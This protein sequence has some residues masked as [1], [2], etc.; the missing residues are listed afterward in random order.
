MLG[1]IHFMP[2]AE[3]HPL[4]A[5]KAITQM[6]KS[7]RDNQ[8]DMKE[9][10]T[11]FEFPKL[12]GE[13]AVGMT[14][15]HIIDQSR[16]EPQNLTSQRELMIHIWYPS[17]E[18]NKDNRVLYRADE[19]EDAKT[20]L[21]KL[22]YP[23][24]DLKQLDEVFSHAKPNAEFLQK[25]YPYP[26]ILFSHGYLGCMPVDYTSFCEEL[27][28][29]GYIVISIAHTYYAQE[30]TFTDGRKIKPST[31]TLAQ[32]SAPNEEVQNLWAKDVQAVLDYLTNV[33]KDVKDQFHN[34]FD[35]N[36]VGMV[37][38]SMGGA[39]AFR[40]CLNDDRFKAGVS[41]DASPWSQ[42]G[43]HEELKKPFLFIFAENTVQDLQKTDEE[44]AAIHNVPVEAVAKFRAI[45]Q[46]EIRADVVIPEINHGGF[47]DFLLLKDLPLYKNNKHIFNI[48]VMT[49][50]ADGKETIQYI[51]DK[52]IQFFKRSL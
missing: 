40:L 36:R 7:E 17:S 16:K 3:H 20:G 4:I 10:D 31:E 19:I 11:M 23:E 22:G 39:T 35:L 1:M 52:L 18:S 26:V 14:T 30:V 9:S 21:N 15:R 43:S 2:S 24:K 13:Y 48:E 41:F 29:H 6:K 49:G 46:Q 5:E 42:D 33:N 34:A 47:N 50:A 51:N 12:T 37:G 25:E 45:S 27:A 32:Q 8:E 28:S 38:H 44:I